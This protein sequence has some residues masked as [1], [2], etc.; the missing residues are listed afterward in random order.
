MK[1]NKN[2]KLMSNIKYWNENK[3][4]I[5]KKLLRMYIKICEKMKMFSYFH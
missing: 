1:L 3:I 2:V 5:K 4:V